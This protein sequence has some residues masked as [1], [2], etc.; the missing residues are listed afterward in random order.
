M[1]KHMRIEIFILTVFF[2][3]LAAS[4]ALSGCCCMRSAPRQ[5]CLK[6]KGC[7][8]QAAL[9]RCS[10]EIARAARP[11]S[12]VLPETGSLLGRQVTVSGKLRQGGGDCTTLLCK[13]GSCCNRCGAQYAFSTSERPDVSRP[14]TLLLRNSGEGPHPHAKLSCH[15]DDSLVC[16]PIAM[17]QEVVAVGRLALA[18]SSIHGQIYMVESPRLCVP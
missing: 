8:A 16:C 9:P 10:Q 11:L 18:G 13:K 15:G 6:E 5:P 4:A 17:G 2:C 1:R 12:A 3:A 7:P 14:D